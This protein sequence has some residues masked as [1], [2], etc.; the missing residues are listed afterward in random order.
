MAN[1]PTPPAPLAPTP[2]APVVP[3]EAAS[4]AAP[5]A[6]AAVAPQQ[7]PP[8]QVLLS[9]NAPEFIYTEKPIGWYVGLAVFFVGLI[10]VAVVTRQW[11]SIGVF[12]IMGVAVAIYANR[13]PRML[14]YSLTNYGIHVGDKKYNFDGF[15]GFFEADD[16]GQLVFELI[17]TK[18]FAPLISL[19][20]VTEYQAQ[21]EQMLGGTL[22]KEAPRISF[23]ERLF[24][25]LRF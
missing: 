24:K 2:A 15:G 10:A 4:Q 1:A 12:A 18:R 19:P 17:P 14:N 21:I 13:K 25:A 11:L 5:A 22:P 7:L 6:Q 20:A 23:I 9:W 3:V 8:E 16:Y